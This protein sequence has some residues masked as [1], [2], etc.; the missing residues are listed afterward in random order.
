MDI[1]ERILDAGA[2]ILDRDGLGGVTLSALADEAG[3]SRVTLHRHG[4]SVSGVVIAVLARASDDLRASLWPAL[5]GPGDAA[6]RLD[7]ALRVLCDVAERHLGVLS[8]LFR[9]SVQPLPDRPERTT[10]FEFI[11]PFERLLVDGNQD[12]SLSS[13][14]P[15]ADATLTANAVTWTYLHMRQAH[16]WAPSTAADAV[17]RMATAS[18]RRPDAV[19]T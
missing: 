16:D 9:A 18:L 7:A 3:L 13:A 5:T 1:D 15:L 14:D 10:S 8:A 11:E 19:E 17:I 12:G 2:V 4:V 6:T